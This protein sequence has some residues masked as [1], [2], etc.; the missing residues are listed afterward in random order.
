MRAGSIYK[1][2]IRTR[3]PIIRT[4]THLAIINTF[5]AAQFLP[6]RTRVALSRARRTPHLARTHHI[7]ASLASPALA[8]VR[9]RTRVQIITVR[10]IR[11]RGVGTNTCR[12]IARS[13]IMTLVL[14]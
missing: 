10:S 14:R 8:A 3:V 5:P 2:I 11:L 13:G 9:L 1:N 4:R 6:T 7:I 12:R